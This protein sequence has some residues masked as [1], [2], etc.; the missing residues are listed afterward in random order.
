[1]KTM[2][3]R[4]NAIDILKA[5]CAFL[6]VCIHIPF[7]GI[8]GMH[9]VTL[10]RIAVPIFFMISGYFY[11]DIIT[12]NGEVR[13]IKKIFRLLLAAN[14]IYV[15]WKVLLSIIWN[16][17]S[18][19]QDTFSMKNLFQFL[20]FNES[21]FNGH[22]WYLGAILY[23]LLIVQILRRMGGQYWTRILY[24]AT[25]L[26]LIGDLLLGKYSILLWGHEF[27]YIFVRNWL[28]VGMPYFSVGLILRE[29]INRSNLQTTPLVCL[30]VI[31]SFTTLTERFFLVS[32]GVNAT[33]DHYISTTFLAVTVFLLFLSIYRLR[34]PGKL[35]L[36]LAFVGRKYSTWVYIIHPI[37]ITVFAV[38]MRKIGIYNVYQYVAPIVIYAVSICFVVVISGMTDWAKRSQDKNIN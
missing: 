23:V 10:A 16:D 22:L 15:L 24:V 4:S 2:Q 6:I 37:F 38:G 25:P 20:M 14:L 29:R 26:L 1:M 18:F 21:P 31:F 27:P 35:G 13:Q 9:I 33:R 3:T 32:A 5:F 34:E 28:F 30:T 19:F 12:R 11:S 36:L 17:E 8:F 7:P